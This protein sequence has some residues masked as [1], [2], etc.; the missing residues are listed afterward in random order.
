MILLN[1]PH[2]LTDL[3]Q[4][5]VAAVLGEVPSVRDIPSQVDRAL[6]LLD[7]IVALVDSVGLSSSEWQTQPLIINPPALAP[8][9]LTLMAELHGL[10]GYFPAILNIRPEA[11]SLPAR[12]EV[13]EI[14]NL[15]MVRDAARSRR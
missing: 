1:F 5:Q 13:A 11:G 7:V 14:V 8:V 2:P 10:C 6:P 12:Y 3:Q 4:K 15:Q 9:A